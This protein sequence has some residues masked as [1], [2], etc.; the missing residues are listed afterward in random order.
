MYY[1]GHMRE[2]NARRDRINNAA[3]NLPCL[4]GPDNNMVDVNTQVLDMSQ[5]LSKAYKC[6]SEYAKVNL[7]SDCIVRS[8][9]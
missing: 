8:C 3:N 4:T 5:S 1:L 2:E 6:V 9:I 7:R